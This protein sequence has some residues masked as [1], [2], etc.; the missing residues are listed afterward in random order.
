MKSDEDY[1]HRLKQYVHQD[2]VGIEVQEIES[3]ILTKTTQKSKVINGKYGI[4]L[5]VL[6]SLGGG[7]FLMQLLNNPKTKNKPSL[8]PTAFEQK[9]LKPI[10]SKNTAAKP[11]VIATNH[12]QPQLVVHK[13]DNALI[14]PTSELIVDIADYNNIASPLID[15]AD[16][17]NITSY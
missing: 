8:T 12:R 9:Q 17:E 11:T 7:G 5:F 14:E 13:L 3:Y 1:L 15:I 10:V 16:Y 2:D 6:L 4:A